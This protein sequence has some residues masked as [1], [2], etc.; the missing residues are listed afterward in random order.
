MRPPPARVP[1]AG[2]RR[3]IHDR[4]LALAFH[5][6]NDVF[7]AQERGLQI[8]VDLPVEHL[9]RHG[10]GVARLGPADI[11]HQDVDAFEPVQ[12]GLHHLLHIRR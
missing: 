6:R 4:A 10:H 8:E 12:A 11:V 7:A 5:H 2:D 3:D 9:F 1:H